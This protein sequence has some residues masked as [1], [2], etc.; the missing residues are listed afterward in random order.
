[1]SAT[2]VKHRVLLVVVA[3]LLLLGPTL[4]VAAD[5]TFGAESGAGK[6]RAT[7][8]RGHPSLG[9]RNSDAEE[10]AAVSGRV[11]DARGNAPRTL[12]V[13]DLIPTDDAVGKCFAA[14]TDSQGRFQF[15]NL[16]AGDYLLGVSLRTMPPSDASPYRPTYYLGT[17][18][19]DAAQIIRVQQG[20]TIESVEFRLPRSLNRRTVT[21]IVVDGKGK[22][23]AGA[24]V[25]VAA[26]NYNRAA[27]SSE[28]NA[29][30]TFRIATVR[31]PYFI[32]ACLIASEAGPAGGKPK[33]F[34]ICS[35][36]VKIG[37]AADGPIRLVLDESKRLDV[38]HPRG[39]M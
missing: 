16:P 2:T 32:R 3:H 31:F 10:K 1:M 9:Y 29:D 34:A 21:G 26:A 33:A 20:Q 17:Q 4:R 38:G 8:H 23:V 5:L 11:V 30:G 35:Q 27:D 7:A 13:L 15:R 25:Q 12:V 19:K 37:S 36:K 6:R 28:T 18:N 14:A 24:G 22:P 39:V